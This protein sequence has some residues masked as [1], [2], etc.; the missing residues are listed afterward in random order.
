[1][2]GCADS[3]VDPVSLSQ[4]KRN[5]AA[6]L[7]GRVC[8]AVLGLATVPIMIRLMGIE[9]Y[10]LVAF[11]VTLQAVFSLL[12]LGLSTTINRELAGMTARGESAADSRDLVRTLETC[13][14]AI[15][16]IIGG[17]MIAASPWVSGWVDPEYLSKGQVYHA[18]LI[19]GIIMALQWP[20]SFYEGGLMGLQRQ[21]TLNAIS[22]SSTALRQIGGVL[23]LWLIS[24]TVHAFLLWQVFASG[25]QTFATA[26]VLWRCLPPATRRPRFHWLI[27]TRVWRFSAGIMATSI[28]TLGLV[29]LDKLVLSR[30][31]SLEHFGY[32][33]LAAVAAGGLHYLIGPIFTAAFPRFSELVALRQHDALR[34]D[35]HRIAQFT[36]VL[37]LSAAMVLITFAPEVMALWTRN[38]EIVAHTYPLVMILAAGTAMNGVI[39]VPYALQLASG[40]T[41]LTMYTNIGA[42]L[43]MVPLAF[44]IGQHFGAP[45][46]ASLSV[47]LNLLY[48]LATVPLMHRRLLRGQQRT[49]YRT[50]VGLPLGV[51]FLSVMIWRPFV[52]SLLSP[53]ELACVLVIV[54]GSTLL[55]TAL[56]TPETRMFLGR[57][58][59]S[60]LPVWTAWP[61]GR[62]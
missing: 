50:D 57:A 29:Q 54:S 56:A 43:V 28:V 38:A 9:A 53:L 44:V 15:A 62:L 12:D 24:P 30:L 37:V 1:M 61:R 48:V 31:L 60:R 33:S 40:W 32:Y 20:L 18:A 22:V 23:V 3:E 55:A 35:Y 39:H 52:S 6:N 25:L 14:W 59:V 26:F 47:A 17:C 10:G 7:S 2:H 46:V 42:L 8:M 27:V 36:S 13:Y 34:I 16:G 41:T 19:M 45:G 21:V 5:I 11:F 58:A 51:A 4:L 49:W